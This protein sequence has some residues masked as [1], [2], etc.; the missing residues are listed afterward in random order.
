MCL[1]QIHKHLQKLEL[2]LQSSNQV[3]SE[4]FFYFFKFSLTNEAGVSYV[5]NFESFLGKKEC[6]NQSSERK[7]VP[8]L[9]KTL[10]VRV[11]WWAEADAKRVG[12]KYGMMAAEKG[13]TKLNE[14][15]I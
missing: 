8:V 12:E 13:I 7:V 10:R 6:L 9:K 4:F 3:P 2:E 14:N 11:C 5:Q 15:T 1:I